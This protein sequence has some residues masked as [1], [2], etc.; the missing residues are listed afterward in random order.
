VEEG[1][2]IGV[3]RRSRPAGPEPADAILCG[4][5][6]EAWRHGDTVPSLGAT[7]R[8]HSRSS[9]GLHTRAKA[10]HLRAVAA[11]GLEGT[12]GH[13]TVL[14]RE[15]LPCG[16]VLSIADSVQIRQSLPFWLPH[17]AAAESVSSLRHN[18]LGPTTGVLVRARDV[19]RHRESSSSVKTLLRMHRVCIVKL[20]STHHKTMSVFDVTSHVFTSCGA[21]QHFGDNAAHSM[22]PSVLVSAPFTTEFSGVTPQ[23]WIELSPAYRFPVAARFPVEEPKKLTSRPRARTHRVSPQGGALLLL[24]LNYLPSNQASCVS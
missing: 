14:I 18:S 5:V 1:T 12:L 23:P 10:M 20:S 17:S 4:L 11:V 15:S 21:T 19:L 24:F 9:L 3:W 16:Q 13:R 2:A 22:L 8:Q 7:P 6:A